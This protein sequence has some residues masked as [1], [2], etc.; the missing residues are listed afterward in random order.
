MADVVG[1]NIKKLES[2]DELQ[3]ANKLCL[4]AKGP[5]N[6]YDVTSLG[7]LRNSLG[8]AESKCKRPPRL[9]LSF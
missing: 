2:K 4:N 1:Q 3:E 8:C 7:F 5:G 9:R 6:E